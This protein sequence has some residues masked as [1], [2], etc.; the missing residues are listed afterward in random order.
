MAVETPTLKSQIYEQ[1]LMKILK[2]EFPMDALLAESQLIK[3]FNVSRAPVREALIELCRDN[4]LNNIP[5]AGYQIVRISEKEMRDAFQLRLILETEGLNM[6]FKRLSDENIEELMEIAASSD[7]VRAEG[8]VEDSLDRKMKL[9]DDFH[10]RLNELSGNTLMYKHLKET[11]Q[12][13]RRGLAQIMIHEYERPFP[14]STFHSGL[15]KALKARD[16]AGA[17]DNL[18]NDILAYERDIWE[19]VS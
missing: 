8:T 17:Q 9:N 12:L 13:M 5:R 6:A 3:M 15:V 7:K 1:L 4:I 19:T 2:N 18:R 10:L 11:I 14:D 16:L